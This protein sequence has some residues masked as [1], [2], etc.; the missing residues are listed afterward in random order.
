MSSRRVGASS[1]DASPHKTAG[2][3]G[4]PF[5]APKVAG[6]EQASPD[7]G[8]PSSDKGHKEPNVVPRDR[9]NIHKSTLCSEVI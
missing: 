9:V 2:D 8:V 6:A 1:A 7:P 4:S 5:K 3:S